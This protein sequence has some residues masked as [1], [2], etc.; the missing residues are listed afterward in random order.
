MNHEAA[1]ELLAGMRR[2]E[3]KILNSLENWGTSLSLTAIGLI[4]KQL[5]DWSAQ[6]S[7]GLPA[8]LVKL[9]WPIYL[10]PAIV[11]LIAFVYLRILNFRIR[12][13]RRALY[14]SAEADTSKPKRSLG[15]VGWSMALMPLVFGFGAALYL[16]IG[17]S[18][19]TNYD[20][21]R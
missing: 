6:T 11:G 7:V 18:Q 13:V 10:L 17:S 15:S 21:R 4:S 1:Q 3:L 19:P 14:E 2:D 16:T 8:G 12:R 9:H 20:P 5:I